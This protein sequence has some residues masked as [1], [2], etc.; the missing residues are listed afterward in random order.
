M[1]RLI[2]IMS[3]LLAAGCGHASPAVQASGPP[4]SLAPELKGRVRID[5]IEV[6]G[7][8]RVID[9]FAQSQSDYEPPKD[10]TEPDWQVDAMAELEFSNAI[11][12]AM[13]DPLRRCAR[14]GK[15]LTARVLIDGLDYDE[16]LS[17]LWDGKGSDRIGGVVELIDRSVQPEQIVAR[18]RLATANRSG[19]LLTR[20]LTDRIDA[21]GEALGEAL[22]AEAFGA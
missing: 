2:V 16:R 22:C 20:I 15:S 10:S 8:P 5:T 4:V 21:M 14:G 7:T 18:V 13:E 6:S 3:G 9:R 1:K 12:M 11:R 19:G 17:S